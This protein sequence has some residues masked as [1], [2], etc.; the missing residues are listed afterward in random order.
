VTQDPLDDIRLEALDEAD[1]LHRS[2]ALETLQRIDFVYAID[3]HDPHGKR[4]GARATAYNRSSET[5]L[6]EAE[7]EDNFEADDGRG[8]VN[9]PTPVTNYDEDGGKRLRVVGE[10]SL[11]F[12]AVSRTNCIQSDTFTFS[13]MRE[14]MVEGSW[15][16]T[17]VS[18]R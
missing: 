18:G 12:F 2:A 16:T 11:T 15:I 17:K 10:F 1:D 3:Q 8:D 4:A 14:A 9:D 13:P 7:L 6:S 5:G